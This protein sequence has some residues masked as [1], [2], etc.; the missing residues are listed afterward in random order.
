MKPDIDPG[1]L[2]G[3]ASGFIRGLIGRGAS[4]LDTIR[5][6]ISGGADYGQQ[7]VTSDVIHEQE[8]QIRAQEGQPYDPDA[9]LPPSFFR[10]R[11]SA[12][13]SAYSYVYEYTY[14]NAK[15]QQVVDHFTIRSNERLSPS[16]LEP[17]VGDMLGKIET[18][19]SIQIEGV[20]LIEGYY[21]PNAASTEEIPF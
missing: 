17:A 16:D 15:G 19:A 12:G 21:N 7:Q 4:V 20:E 8:Q 9:P 18:T 6:I 3:I 2:R 1:S 13:G 5:T 14:T 10:D 11:P